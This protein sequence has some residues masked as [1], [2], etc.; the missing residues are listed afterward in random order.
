LADEYYAVGTEI[1]RFGTLLRLPDIPQ[2]TQIYE[3][4]SDLVIKNGD[5]ILQSGEILDQQLSTWF[6]YHNQETKAY[7][8]AKVLVD[9]SKRKYDEKLKDLTQKKQALFK[10]ADVKLWGVKEDNMQEAL[11][12]KDNLQAASKF[13][14]P[15]VSP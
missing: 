4:F 9:T 11:L 3:R 7:R 8:D 10:K 1:K 5:F 15:K 13:M 2:I 14:L 6:K 12:V